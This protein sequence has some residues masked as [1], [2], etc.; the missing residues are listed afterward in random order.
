MKQKAI[1]IL[2]GAFDPIHNGHLRLAIEARDKLRLD[3]VRLVPT[4][5]SPFGKSFH[6]N[7]NDRLKMLR[8]AVEDI[9]GLVADDRELNKGGISYTIDTVSSL[10][11]E[12]D[13]QPIMLIIGMDAF[14]SL[15]GWKAWRS[16]TESAHIVVANR[17]GNVALINDD[18]LLKFYE[19][20]KCSMPHDLLDA[21]SGKILMIDIPM[22]EISSTHIRH[23][24]S[25]QLDVRYLM[26]EAVIDYIHKEAIYQQY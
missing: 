20:R 9:N 16:I 15:P 17:P 13:E 21:H 5:E 10:R 7:S 8:I 11:E 22:L 6:A 4:C 2:G 1:G 23:Q 3:E 18:L 26:P 19:Q 14:Q 24:L 25:N 12:Y